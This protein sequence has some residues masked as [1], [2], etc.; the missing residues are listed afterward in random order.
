MVVLYA[1]FR[2][3]RWKDEAPCTGERFGHIHGFGRERDC[4]DTDICGFE[5]QYRI[6]VVPKAKCCFARFGKVSVRGA[7]IPAT[8]CFPRGFSE[9]SM[10]L[11]LCS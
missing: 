3:A 5:R 8:C 4:P 10:A 6:L 1:L 11:R 7:T 2:R 9:Q